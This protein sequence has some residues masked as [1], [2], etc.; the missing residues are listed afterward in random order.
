M[1]FRLAESQNLLDIQAGPICA[2][3]LFELQ[4][5]G[6]IL[7]LVVHHLCV[8]MVSWRI[9]LQD[10]QDC[11]ELGALSPDKT[12]SFQS[13]CELQTREAQEGCLVQLPFQA[14]QP[15]LEYWG[16]EK[17]R[18]LYGHVK[19]ETFT[20]TQEATSFILGSCHDVFRSETLEVLL[21]AVIHSFN[22]VFTDRD[23]PMIYNEGHGREPWD[24]SI[25]VSRTVGWFTTFCPLRVG[26]SKGNFTSPSTHI[27]RTKFVKT[28][29]FDTLR[30]VKDVRRA[31]S[32][33]GRSY[34]AQDLLH[35]REKGGV[36][37]FPVPLEIIFNYLGQMQQLE[38]EDSLF[39][40][41]DDASSFEALNSASDMGPET[42]RFA[43]FELSAIVIKDRLHMSFTYNRQTKHE[44]RIQ[45][46]VSECKKAL[47]EGIPRLQDWLP[48]PT[49]SD[50]PLLSITYD[51]L[52][53]MMRDILPRAG[54]E[55]WERVE[56]IY[57]CSPVQEGILLSQLR[58]PHGYMFHAIIEVR[59]GDGSTRVEA[60]K[61]RKAW[62]MVV[63][64][65]PILRTM[66]I[67]SYCKGGS[68]DQL[69]LRVVE[70]EVIEFECDERIAF[71]TLDN[72]K[73]ANINAKRLRKLHQQL[74]ICTTTSGRVFLK[75]EI[76]HAIIDGASV[77]LLLRDLQMA[78]DA[79]LPPGTGPLFSDYIKHTKATDPKK[80][81][82]HWVE[83]LSDV[84]PC[85]LSVSP[86]AGVE[87]RLN[88]VMMNFDRFSEL[89]KFCECNSVT[90]A[91]L[92]LSAWAIVLWSFTGMND[93]CFGYLSAGRDSPVPGIQEAVGI[94]INMLCC[95]VKFEE[96]QKLC[97]ISRRVQDDFF[98]ALPYQNCSLAQ[99]QH[100]IGREGQMLFNTALSIQN[101]AV[102]ENKKEST[103]SFEFQ[104]AHDPTE[105]SREIPAS[106]EPPGLMRI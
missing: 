29:L 89:Q 86:A 10:I 74:T 88:S 94:F 81:L 38:R 48:E 58:D 105:V 97:D 7:A 2:G 56:D 102:S 34:F 83:Y 40:H 103:I 66:F 50:Y 25:D 6:Q 13:W 99:I 101:H 12:L 23:A 61:V 46:W 77:D 87:R 65:H 47:E 43:L 8:D 31:I 15:N 18:N 70:D 106:G 55:S 93:V 20:V 19:M 75:F 49:L 68:F 33:N 91:N 63:E 44:S 69:V 36:T 90:L 76:N 62:S 45:Q 5:H 17:A 37:Q 59:H 21:A 28:D 16:M 79:Q 104:R 14:Q 22:Q 78:Y 98:R 82:T 54:I 32:G 60:N 84:R 3:D 96:S 35:T 95:R 11:I 1:R 72:I 41:Y 100:E 51:G 64:R 42:P 9:I 92:T 53:N 27:I 80:S 71:E 30:Y 24:D 73:L 26:K 39:K 4:G 67:D 52:K 57:P 85:H